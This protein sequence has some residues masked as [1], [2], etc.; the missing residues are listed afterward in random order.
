MSGP[1]FDVN[2]LQNIEP[3]QWPQEAAQ[4]ILDALSDPQA[5]PSERVI[6][7][8]L[9]G[10]LVVMNDEVAEALIAVVGDATEPDELRAQAAISFGPVLEQTDLDGFDEWEWATMGRPSPRR[11][12]TRSAHC[13]SRY[14]PIRP[15][16]RSAA[17]SVEAAVRAPEEWHRDA[18]KKAY[19]SGDREWMLTAVFG[20]R[21]IQGFNGPIL[22]A[23]NSKDEEIHF[24][25]INAAGDREL[26][27]AW[28]HVKALV[29]NPKT[30]KAI[31]FAA[32]EAVSKIRP[33]ETR[34]A[35]QHLADSPNEEIA[36]AADD[37]IGMAEAMLAGEDPEDEG[38][39]FG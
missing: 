29:Q 6:A 37:A 12:S 3:W 14:T 28:P 11:P 18:I 27:A 10:D 15:P 20:M 36:E 13:S 39:P 5:K 16:P 2:L 38:G 19:A 8:D 34:E 23:L 35:L 30:P 7:A 4:T 17:Q 21:Y 26:D 33:A 1:H 32:I 9:A 24:E 22:E 25:A 31:L